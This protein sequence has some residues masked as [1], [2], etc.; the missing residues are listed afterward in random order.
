MRLSSVEQTEEFAAKLAADLKPNSVL[1]LVGELGAGKTA[2]VRGLAKGLG[3]SEHEYVRSPTFTL[4]NIYKGKFPLYHFDLY[5]LNSTEELLDIGALEYFSADGICVLEWA[6][7][8]PELM[9]KDSSWIELKV[10]SENEREL[11]WLGSR[12]S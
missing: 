4:L 5:R 11:T 7:L 6:N 10:V 2:F 1:C 3:V 12:D 9:P 8:F